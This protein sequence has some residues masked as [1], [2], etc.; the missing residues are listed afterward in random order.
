MNNNK[1]KVRIQNKK[2]N[3]KTIDSFEVI[4][5]NTAGIDIG[6]SEHWVSVHP[7]SAEQSVQKFGTFT[8]D[9]YSIADWL[10]KCNVKY[11]AM[12]S[13]G[14][15]WIP[16]FQILE[17]KGFDVSLIN[18][19][20]IKIV[21]AR[22][23]T[24]RLDCEWIRRLHSCGLL[25]PSFRPEPEICKIRTLLRHRDNLIKMKTKHVQHMQ[26]SLELMSIK[27]TNVI[28]DI[29]GVTG[30]AIIRAILNNQRDV[31][32]LADLKDR[33]IRASKDQIAKSLQGHYREEHLCT[34][35]LALDAVEFTKKQMCQLDRR[36]ENILANF[37]SQHQDHQLSF[38][39]DDQPLRK[40]KRKIQSH[41]ADYDIDYYLRQITGVDL[42][43]IKGVKDS[44]LAIVSEIGLDLNKW[45]TAKHFTSWIGIA[46]K[47]KISGGKVITHRTSKVKSRIARIFRNAACTLRSSDCYLGA[48]Y[49]HIA[50]RKGPAC[51][52]TATARKLAVIVYHMLKNGSSYK[53]LGSDYILKQREKSVLRN[54][55]RQAKSL[56][57]SVSLTKN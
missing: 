37:D 23:K 26:K 32:K 9:L 1:K 17:E 18:A 8:C 24:D 42:T 47:P 34:L 10:A 35:Q 40:K 16:L 49:R 30:L 36:I 43:A 27:L 25:T 39:F 53:D 29:I 14:I 46:P 28:S 13:T 19:R 38:E 41:D 20:Q 51:A 22:G 31:H 6:S 15:Y 52:V 55:Q 44:A 12:E 56:G 57:Y 54:I 5:P 3:G 21:E 4:R 2:V 48:F 50:R 33:R 7:D 11:V 45:P